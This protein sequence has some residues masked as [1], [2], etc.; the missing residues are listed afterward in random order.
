MGYPWY[1]EPGNGGES[2]G[3]GMARR[4]GS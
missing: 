4:L 2:Q 1:S 3:D